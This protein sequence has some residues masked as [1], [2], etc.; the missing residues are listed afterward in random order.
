MLYLP[1]LFTILLGCMSK[2]E[3]KYVIIMISDGWGYNQ[4]LATDYW[5]GTTAGYE[6]WEVAYAM[7]TY[8][9]GGSYDTSKAWS[10]FNYHKLDYTDSAAAS[11]AMSAGV[12]TYNGAIGVD[13]NRRPLEHLIERAELL[14]MATGVITSVMWAHATPAGFVAHDTSRSN[15]VQIASEM[16]YNSAV[17]VIMGA[18]HPLYGNDGESVSGSQ[19]DYRYVGGSTTWTDLVA[20]TA[21]GDADR[22]G[23]DDPWTLIQTS[24]EFQ[25]LTTGDTPNRVLGTAQVRHTLQYSRSSAPPAND[26]ESPY[27][28]SLISTVPTLEEMTLAALNTLDNDPDGFFLMIEG[29]AVDWA[30]HD[31][32]LG[33][34]IEEMDDFNKAFDSVVAWVEANSSWEEA[35]VIVTGDHECGYL[36][37]PSS[38]APAT[39][40]TIIDNGPSVMP[41]FEY[42]SN[43]HT[44]SLIP[45]FAKGIGSKRFKTYANNVDPVR[46]PYI[47][48]INIADVIFPLYEEVTE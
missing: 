24:E 6:S 1:L 9:H 43:S 28:V 36:L 41:G 45:L 37:G 38:G 39:F 21:G 29:G 15:Y 48:N 10:D 26:P 33:R 32:R 25:N 47:D 13:S 23:I 12:K 11:T 17:D 20:G 3:V 35:L 8:S 7:T 18:G 46:G 4:I 44:N 31:K 16:V 30:N 5:N 14:G 40:N 2:S 22:D 19:I 27:S 42:Y 34:M